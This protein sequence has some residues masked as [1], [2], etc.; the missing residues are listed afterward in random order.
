VER[1]KRFLS[2]LQ[3]SPRRAIK[4]VQKTLQ[5]TNISPFQAALAQGQFNIVQMAPVTKSIRN[6][7][8]TEILWTIGLIITYWWLK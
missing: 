3:A 7:I 4:Y 6:V 2:R 1:Q 5:G 8:S